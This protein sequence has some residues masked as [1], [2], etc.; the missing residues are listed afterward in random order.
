[1]QMINPLEHRP[2]FFCCTV[3]VV[4]GWIHREELTSRPLATAMF[5]IQEI[6]LASVF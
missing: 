1:M 4:H 6:L 5:L 2:A 3:I